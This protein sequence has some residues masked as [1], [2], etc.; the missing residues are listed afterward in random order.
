MGLI[1]SL[2]FIDTHPSSVFVLHE[3]IEKLIPMHAHTKGQL[4]FVEGGIAYLTIDKKTFV[5][6]AK[7]FFW[8]PKN[9]KHIL[10]VGH[11]ATVLRSLYFYSKDDILSPYYSSFGIYPASDLLIEMI[12]Y[13]ERWDSIHI[14]PKDGNFEFVCS[15]KKLLPQI[16]AS[17]VSLILPV[18][19]DD[20]L[21]AI[22]NYMN[23][24]IE[25]RLS[26]ENVS[27]YFNMS[28]RSMSRLFQSK[29]QIT[30]LQYLKTLRITKAIELIINT[31]LSINEISRKV[32]YASV[33]S[34]SRVF[35]EL[36][37]STPTDYRKY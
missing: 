33:S 10:R 15:I 4:S 17:T 8:I 14:K 37:R 31:N 25:N 30:F 7:H 12:K 1:A 13:T 29:A 34:F 11:T 32:G 27:S 36:T 22:V 35:T 16:S 24:N 5:V 26:L 23:K 9:V 18:I 28:E 3:K 20:T 21:K 19:K 6:P 2:P